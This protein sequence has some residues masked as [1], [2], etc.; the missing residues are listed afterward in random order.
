MDFTP[1]QILIIV[2]F[3][4]MLILVFYFAT[5]LERLKLQLAN[6]NKLLLESRE[7]VSHSLLACEGLNRALKEYRLAFGEFATVAI[8]RN[9]YLELS[10]FRETY[11][12]W[13]INPDLHEFS[14]EEIL[15]QLLYYKL[16]TLSPDSLD[17]NGMIKRSQRLGTE[18]WV[19]ERFMER[20]QHP[21]YLDSL[22]NNPALASGDLHLVDEC[23][24]DILKNYPKENP[25]VAETKYIQC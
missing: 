6:T 3:I 9:I 20:I 12:V 10:L 1:M 18:K 19:R 17:I 11:G 25:T 8:S 15:P 24:R 22:T 21:D 14:F 7:E 2:P 23:I 5:R 13:D 16:I 4:A